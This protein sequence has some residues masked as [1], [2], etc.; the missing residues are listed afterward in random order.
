MELVEYQHERLHA[1]ERALSDMR[2]ALKA[3]A[4]AL[5]ETGH[6]PSIVA[7]ARL[8]LNR[9]RCGDE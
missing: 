6:A 5:A 8:V 7:G 1:L 3:T 2:D 4:A 9:Y